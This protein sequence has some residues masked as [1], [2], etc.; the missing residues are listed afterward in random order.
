MKRRLFVFLHLAFVYTLCAQNEW[1][2]QPWVQ[3]YGSVQGQQLGN[4]VNGLG[5]TQDSS[6]IGVATVNDLRIFYIKTQQD[7]T[8]RLFFQG[9]PSA[10][11]DF[12][13]DGI[14]DL[15]VGGKPTRIFLGMEDGGFGSDPFFTKHP[16][17]S[18]DA[19]GLRLGV[20][21]I[22]LDGFDDLIVTAAGYPDGQGIGKVYVFFGATAMDT[23][24]EF[25][26]LGDNS[27]AGFGWNVAIGDISNDGRDDVI[28]RGYDQSSSEVTERFAYLK[29]YNGGYPIDS[30][31][32]HVI[33]G[34]SSSLSGLA[35]FDA[36]GDGIDD[37][38]WTNRDS[39]DWVYVHYG[40]A[41]F[42][43]IPSVR[44][45]NPGV[46]NFGAVL[47]NAGDMN[48]DGGADI[49]AS[50]GSGGGTITSGFV[51]I[52]S[53]GPNIDPFFDAA[54]GQSTDSRFGTSIAGIEDINGDGL[55]DI[56]VGAPEY[57]F[58]TNK[59][60]WGIFL[61]DTNIPVTSVESP[62]ETQ[63]SVFSL[64]SNYPNPFN[65]QTTI[66]YRIKNTSLIRLAISNLLGQELETL[67]KQK[68]P[69]GEY[70]VPFDA[71]KYPSGVYLYKLT[72]IDEDGTT[73][74][75]TK[76]MTLIK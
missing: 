2:L 38:L 1:T 72:V 23:I 53:G 50:T 3:V 55:S 10:L 52:F 49:A 22:N 27:A 61:G 75:E 41:L 68:Q 65:S 57:D 59:G 64:L 9:R 40:G 11:G 19:F 73:R 26:V 4:H 30:N 45:E 5:N 60:Y 48:G 37:L 15:V 33:K 69:P 32:S 25:T 46:A 17:S 16:E 47:A 14:K 44:L 29:I 21:K 66:V 56:I 8:P 13:G 71:E 28:I 20:G 12:N 42:D 76:R 36:N 7:T 58:G 43:T 34:G 31:A 35:S 24:P 39:L 51:F 67:L 18:Q 74:T 54:V 62:Q 70:R 63:P 6:R